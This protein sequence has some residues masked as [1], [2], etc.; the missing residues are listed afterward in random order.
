VKGGTRDLREV[1]GHARKAAV[2]GVEVDSCPERH[3]MWLDVIELDRIEDWGFDEDDLKGSLIFR[4]VTATERCP[5]CRSRLERFQYRLND[6]HLDYCP[7][8]HGYWLDADEDSRVIELMNK[9]ETDMNR[10]AAAEADWNETLERMRS[11]S[12]VTK[13][14]KHLRRRSFLYRLRNKL[15]W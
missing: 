6:L 5:H 2:H 3:G 8:H 11:R 9:R 14:G 7:N 15:P 1:H 10:K 4:Q 13:T 12:L